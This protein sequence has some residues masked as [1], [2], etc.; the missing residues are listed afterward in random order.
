MRL[1]ILHGI[2]FYGKLDYELDGDEGYLWWQKDEDVPKELSE[3]HDDEC[4]IDIVD[5]TTPG[6]PVAI[7][8]ISAT[9]TAVALSDIPAEQVQVVCCEGISIKP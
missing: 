6:H 4:G 1:K 8:A 2:F 9:K 5:L 3:F 7:A